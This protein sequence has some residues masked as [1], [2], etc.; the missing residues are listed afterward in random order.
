MD[1]ISI[2]EEI[3]DDVRRYKVSVKDNN[4]N[5]SSFDILVFIVSFVIIFVK[6]FKLFSWLVI[7]CFISLSLWFRKGE[8]IEESLIVIRDLGVQL[9]TKYRSGKQT[10]LFIDKRRIKSIIINEGIKSYNFI[11]YM[12]FIVEGNNRMI[13]AFHTLFPRLN[14]LIPVYRGTRAIMFG[15]PE[16]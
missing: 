4:T 8:V 13:L 5:F 14:T 1:L 9:E 6:P 12:A 16:E 3:S 11:F 15:E 10:H 7:L 2:C